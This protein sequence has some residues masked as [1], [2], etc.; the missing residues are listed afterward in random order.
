MN[1]TAVNV[2]VMIAAVEVA[3][4]ERPD[5]L[6]LTGILELTGEG[7]KGPAIRQVMEPALQLRRPSC[8]APVPGWVFRQAVSAA[9]GGVC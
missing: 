6:E 2:S 5:S 8:A 4:A 1:G 9:P 3:D 7:Q